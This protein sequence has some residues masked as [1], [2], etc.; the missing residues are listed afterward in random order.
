MK[1][2]LE[3]AERAVEEANDQK[4]AAKDEAD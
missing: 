4:S 1:A 2:S 3:E